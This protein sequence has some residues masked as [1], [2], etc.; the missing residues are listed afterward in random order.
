MGDKEFQRA[1]LDEI[2]EKPS[3]PEPDATNPDHLR[4]CA[5]V[6]DLVAPN[7]ALDPIALRSMADRCHNPT[8]LLDRMLQAAGH[9]TQIIEGTP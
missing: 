5:D 3:L 6:V 7:D 4:W 8:N 2:A 9:T 1:R